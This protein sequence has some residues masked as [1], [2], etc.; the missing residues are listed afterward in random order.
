METDILSFIFSEDERSA[1]SNRRLAG[2][3]DTAVTTEDRETHSGHPVL[4]QTSLVFHDLSFLLRETVAGFF[5]QAC[6]P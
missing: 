6:P 4:F 2:T 5:I 3:A 1:C